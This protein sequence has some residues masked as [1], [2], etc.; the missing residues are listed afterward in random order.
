MKEGSGNVS[1]KYLAYMSCM[2]IDACLLPWDEPL[3][4]HPHVMANLEI[5]AHSKLM[6]WFGSGFV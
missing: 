3:Y 5:Y 2:L 4:L 1:I 6:P